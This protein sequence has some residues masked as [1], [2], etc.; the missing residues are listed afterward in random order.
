MELFDSDKHRDNLAEES[1]CHQAGSSSS[2]TASDDIFS[3]V[4]HLQD[5]FSRSIDWIP[6]FPAYSKRKQDMNIQDVVKD[7][8]LRFLPAKSLVRFR[9]VSKDWDPWIRSPLLG[10]QQSYS[11][12]DISGFFYEQDYN[13][14]NF[15]TLNHDAYGVPMPSLTFLPCPVNIRSSSNGLLLCQGGENYSYYVCN[16]VT[17]AVMELPESVYY[18]GL[19]PAVVL[20]FEPSVLNVGAH[21]HVICAVPLPDH[22]V[23]CFELYSARTKKWMCSEELCVGLENYWQFVGNGF[24]MK[25]IVY[26]QTST[27]RV[28]TFDL[29][30]KVHGVITLPTDRPRNGILAEIHGKLCYI[31]IS[32]D[33]DNE[34]CIKIYSGEDLSLMQRIAMELGPVVQPANFE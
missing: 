12:R 32:S 1:S 25:G 3:T 30:Q 7:S 27:G 26:C 20:A 19:D 13:V 14:P 21:Y 2:Q 16:P 33:A 15:V 9:A 18:H 8:V 4:Q 23:V 34:W 29:E 28:V 22:P 24:Y 6:R 17:K 31:G 10:L 5:Q 11:F